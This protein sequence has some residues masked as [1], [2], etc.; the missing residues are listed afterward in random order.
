M[1]T[2]IS[3]ARKQELEQAV[4]DLEERGF[5]VIKQ[6]EEVNNSRVREK[7]HSTNRMEQKSSVNIKYVALMRRG[8]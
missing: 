2:K 3:R 5:E 7:N 4:S 8:R 6:G 1:N